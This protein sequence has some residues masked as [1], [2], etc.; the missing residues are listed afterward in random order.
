MG[1]WGLFVGVSLV[2]R[3]NVIVHLVQLNVYS[4]VYIIVYNVVYTFLMFTTFTSLFTSFTMLF[5]S[6]FTSFTSLFTPF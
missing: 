5:T 6:L 3:V 2:S 4:F 1:Y